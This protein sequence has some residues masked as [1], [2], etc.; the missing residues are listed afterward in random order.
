MRKSKEALSALTQTLQTANKHMQR[1]VV[2]C[3]ALLDSGY[4]KRFN[5]ELRGTSPV[6]CF[7]ALTVHR[8]VN[9]FSVPDPTVVNERKL[10]CYKDWVAFEERLYEFNFKESI[11]QLASSDLTV[12]NRAR[13]KLIAYMNNQRFK[14]EA[15]QIKLTPGET[16]IS[17]KGEVSLVHKFKNKGNWSIAYAA[18]DAAVDLINR[19]RGCLLNSLV[20]HYLDDHREY[21]PTNTTFEEW[22]SREAEEATRDYIYGAMCHVCTF[23]EGARAATVPK[24]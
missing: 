6:E 2:E 5:N 16:F 19:S 18:L 8:L 17:Q 20:H 10:R 1:A 9:K 12:L 21:M 23:T 15:F 22:V 3:G 7:N 4:V 14:P 24:K 11:S 13:Y